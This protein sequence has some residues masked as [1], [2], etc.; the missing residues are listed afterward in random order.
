MNEGTPLF[1]LIA[2]VVLKNVVEVA[3]CLYTMLS[4]ESA[5]EMEK[6]VSDKS[7]PGKDIPNILSQ[8]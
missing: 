5:G 6:D 2:A 8:L 7:W 1:P 3:T 4:A